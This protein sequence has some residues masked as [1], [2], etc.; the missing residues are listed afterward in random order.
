MGEEGG[1]LRRLP[2]VPLPAR[3]QASADLEQEFQLHLELRAAELEAEGLTSEEARREALR[4]FG[5]PERVRREMM[6]AATRHVREQRGREAVWNM[7]RDVRYAA[8]SLLRSP[9]FTVVAVATL[10]VGIGATTAIFS[11]VD[12]VLLRP[13]PIPE[14]DRVAMI[15]EARDAA[16]RN[17]GNPANF[18]DWRARSEEFQSMAAV[19]T[20]PVTVLSGG[21]AQQVAMQLAHPDLFR[22]LGVPLRLG[23]TFT[24]EEA[25]GEPGAAQVV[26]LSHAFWREH[27]GGDPSVV[28]ETVE[29]V[30]GR[31]EVIGVMGPELEFFAPEV[32]FWMPSDYEW[33]NRTDMGRFTRA[34]GRLAPGATMETA[35]SELEIIMAGLRDEYPDFNAEWSANVVPLDEVVKGDVRPAL[36]VLLGAVGVLLLVTCVNVANLMLVRAAS[37]RTEVAVRAS[38]GAS[39]GR[40]IRELLT[41]SLLLSTVGGA[42]GVGL[43]FL[44][45]RV[46]V[47]AVPAA[48][49]VPRLQEA[50]VSL[51]VLGFGA[52]VA[53]ATGVVFGLAPAVNAFRSDLVGQLREGGRGGGGGLRAR[54]IRSAIVVAEVALSLL[55]L[56]GA[57]LLLRSFV[58]LQRTDL[59]LQPENVVTGQIT[60]GG[61]RYAEA[62]SRASFLDRTVESIVAL[63]E[64]RTAGAISH[65]P[66]TGMWSGHVYYLAGQ[67]KPP[68]SQMLPAEVQAVEGRLFDALGMPLL[69]GRHF[70]AAD[71]VGAPNVVIVNEALA[72]Q[73]WPGRS[74]LGRRIVVPWGEDEEMEVVGVVGNVRQ[75]GVEEQ[76]QP[77]LYRPHAQFPGFR[78]MTLVARTAAGNE[79]AVVRS[80]AE[81]VREIDPNMAVAEVRTMEEVVADAVARPRLTSFLVAAFAAIALFLAALGIYGV[82]AYAVSLRTQELGLRQAL[83]ATAAEVARLVLRDAAV[84]AGLGILL[85]GLAAV[86]GARILSSQL[87]QVS[88]RDPLVFLGMPALLLL[89]AMAAAALPALRAGRVRPTLAVRDD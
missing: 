34:V 44:A 19:F 71:R 78:S 29:L 73:A 54:R 30:G 35:Q 6:G 83:G 9:A 24:L 85:G 82:L 89:I 67:P 39:R 40:I 5:D 37:R 62:E 17:P 21:E 88:P 56:I 60:M 32:A 63:P 16:D 15:Y 76:G 48:L 41:E 64:V 59:G 58:E 28:G 4:L 27:F 25:T 72:E 66:L 87:Y 3:K 47:S 43:A 75:R 18:L 8:R 68:T 55:L 20:T 79:E 2:R 1:R 26:V 13:L 65:L 77:G 84:L 33:S 74:A 42:A 36:L 11:L 57:G 14:P 23:R 12:A 61:E 49:Q 86:A 51:G 31:A 70:T 7:V 52:L 69:E 38:L 22:V 46:L 53:V 45:T 81:R 80:L 50:G 10:A